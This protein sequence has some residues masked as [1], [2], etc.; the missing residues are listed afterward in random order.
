MHYHFRRGKNANE[1]FFFQISR[2]NPLSCNVDSREKMLNSPKLTFIIKER[3]KKYNSIVVQ[4]RITKKI[5]D[6]EVIQKWR[7]ATF[8]N[9]F[10]TP[11]PIVMLFSSKALVLFPQNPCRH[12]WTTLC[13]HSKWYC[14]RNSIKISPIFKGCP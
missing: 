6:L 8:F 4:P 3:S 5:K 14:N 13:Y 9:F 10:D 2:T 7:H 11:L 1:F 12:L